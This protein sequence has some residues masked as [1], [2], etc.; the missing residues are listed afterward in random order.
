MKKIKLSSGNTYYY[1][2]KVDG[3]TWGHGA[4][5]ATGFY[6]SPQGVFLGGVAGKEAERK[7]KVFSSMSGN[8]VTTLERMPDMSQF[9]YAEF[10][11]WIGSA[12]KLF[13]D[14]MNFVFN[15][16][17]H[18]GSS[19]VSSACD[20][21]QYYFKAVGLEEMY[22][23][24]IGCPM[25]AIIANHLSVFGKHNFRQTFMRGSELKETSSDQRVDDEFTTRYTKESFKAPAYY[26]R[27]V[28]GI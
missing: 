22:Q 3:D 6:V 7:F 14:H 11:G 28:V 20:E 16:R 4:K 9:D 21:R 2:P 12:S 24:R 27:K 23:T 8:E 5:I 13:M 10:C 1:S 26:L 15:D 25:W 18:G 19:S 17:D